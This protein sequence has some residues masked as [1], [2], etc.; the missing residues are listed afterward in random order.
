MAGAHHLLALVR[1]SHYSLLLRERGLILDV[2]PP[3][4]LDVNAKTTVRECLCIKM[5]VRLS[6]AM[7]WT[8]ISYICPLHGS[9]VARTDAASDKGCFLSG[10][11]LFLP[12][13]PTL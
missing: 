12:L 1:S 11:L 5:S 2:N 4:K 7:Q 8:H 9:C 10:L 13:L 3:F 6:H